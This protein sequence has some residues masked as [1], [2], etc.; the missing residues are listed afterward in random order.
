[1][2]FKLVIEGLGDRDVKLSWSTRDPD[3]DATPYLVDRSMLLRAGE[4]LRRELRDI[5]NH[6]L[7]S[8]RRG[9]QPAYTARLEPLRSAGGVLFNAIFDAQDGDTEQA[10][11]IREEIQKHA[12]ELAAGRAAPAN[13]AIVLRDDGVLVPWSFAFN[14]EADVAPLASDPPDPGRTLRLKDFHGFWLSQFCIRQR[15][16]GLDRL[17]TMPRTTPDFRGLHIVNEQLFTDAMSI[18]RDRPNAAGRVNDVF[19]QPLRPGNM[20]RDWTATREEWARIKDANDSV[21]FVF[22]HSDGEM[23]ELGLAP[24]GQD[25]RRYS[26]S[27]AAFRDLIRKAGATSASF[28][29]LNACRTASPDPNPGGALFNASFLK[30]TRQKGFHG[31]IGT[32]AEVGNADSLHYASEFLYLIYAEGYSV[33]EAFDALAARED[34]LP[35]NFYYSCFALPDFR[36]PRPVAISEVEARSPSPPPSAP[37]ASI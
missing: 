33:G 7:D 1:M 27:S 34:L 14:A 36:I 26:L 9:A 5:T 25:R 29:F 8:Q 13:L 16:T 3:W 23:I 6:G 37:G 2:D 35:F 24:P 20:V 18:L 21:V 11:E 17:P 15:F 22:G 19:F 12:R 31:F 32:E 4:D 28:C 30:A 10:R